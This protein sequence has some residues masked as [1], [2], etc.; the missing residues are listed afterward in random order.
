MSYYDEEYDTEAFEK[1][2]LKSVN[3]A[4]KLINGDYGKWVVLDT[5]TTGLWSWNEPIEIGVVSKYGSEIFNTR[6]WLRNE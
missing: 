6:H 2:K 4:R 3:W 5:E 1:D